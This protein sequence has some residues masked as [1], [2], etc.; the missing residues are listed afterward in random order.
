MHTN[1]ERISTLHNLAA[2]L[3]KKDQ[4]RKTAAVMILS[5]A[6]CIC[7]LAGIAVLISQVSPSGFTED[8]PGIMSASIFSGSSVL[9]FLVIAILAFLLG[10]SFTI[11]CFRLKKYR[12]GKDRRDPQ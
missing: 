1:E 10:I 9:G 11:F 6:V 3:K 2:Q 7:I 4:N 12:D 8:A 5:A